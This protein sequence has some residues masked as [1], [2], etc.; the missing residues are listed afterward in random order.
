MNTYDMIQNGGKEIGRQQERSIHE[1]ILAQERQRA[2]E[3]RQR[4][5]NTIRYLSWELNMSPMD[6]SVIVNKELAY[7]ELMLASGAKE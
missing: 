6:I 2:D 3:E 1:E 5:D 7:S 4:L